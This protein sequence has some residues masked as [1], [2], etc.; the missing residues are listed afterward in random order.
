M[1]SSE[2]LK[3][4]VRNIAKE[5]NL[6]S[7]EV[8]QMFFFER[9]LERLSN[10]DYKFNFIIKG[11]L[12]ISSMIGIDNRS[13]MDMDTT[14]KGIPLQEDRI[15]EIV[16]GI[17]SID[18]HDG[19]VFEITGINHI[20]EEDEY[21][22]FRIH[23]IAHFGKIKNAMKLDITTGDEIIPREI[24][25][26]YHS[27]FEKTIIRILA[28]PL[29]TILAEKY[30]TIIKR[31]IAT[32]RMRDYYDLYSLYHLRKD[33][34]DFEV[35]KQAIFAT[36]AKRESLSFIEEAKEIIEDIRIDSY[37]NDLW[38]VY[39]KDNPYIGQLKFIDAVAVVNIIAEK[40]RD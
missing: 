4:K 31:N 14:V 33:E 13:T 28:Y 23:L 5:K 25:Y 38:Q 27:M 15:K 34:I 39:L 21:E 10:S 30:E 12:L 32:T 6:S 24:E 11:G 1:I 18:V 2:S 29:E 8:L 40:I 9:F 16:A 20:R 19:I 35:L 26:S 7:Q 37:L 36:A 17:V 22:N 3:G